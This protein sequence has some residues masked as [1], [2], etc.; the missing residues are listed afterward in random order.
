MRKHMSFL[1]VLIAVLI[2]P[3]NGYPG[4]VKGYY[5]KNGTYVAPHYRKNRSSSSTYK[6]STS[7]YKRSSSK[8]YTSPSSTYSSGYS[9]SSSGS[10]R[11]RSSRSTG[12][13]GSGAAISEVEKISRE[14]Q[15]TIDRLNQIDEAIETY[16]S[17]NGGRLPQTLQVL[18][19]STSKM[20]LMS[21]G[22]GIRLNYKVDGANY[23]LSSNGPDK[24]SGTLDDIYST[25]STGVISAK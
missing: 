7:T 6:P 20:L 24:T 10:T 25:N 5:R 13:A 18:W 14:E 2:L 23:L 12:T 15:T 22:W 17:R 9:S 16:K 11:A 4:Y 3:E 19:R 1:A 21:D 8:T